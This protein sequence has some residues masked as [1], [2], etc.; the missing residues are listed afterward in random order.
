MFKQRTNYSPFMATAFTFFV[1]YKGDAVS[2]NPCQ[3]VNPPFG[4]PKLNYYK[5]PK[6]SI[7]FSE[8]FKIQT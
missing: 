1:S 7:P 2:L 8:K 4:N 6:E 3:R 5:Y